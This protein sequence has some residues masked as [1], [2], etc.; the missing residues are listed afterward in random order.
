VLAGRAERRSALP[1]RALS[2]GPY[3]PPPPPSALGARRG[4]GQPLPPAS[5]PAA[6]ALKDAGPLLRPAPGSAPA[7]PRAR[8][9]ARAAN[10]RAGACVRADG[11]AQ[12]AAGARGHRRA[13]RGADARKGR[14]AGGCAQRRGAGTWRGRRPARRTAACASEPPRGQGAGVR[15]QAGGEPALGVQRERLAAAGRGGMAPRGDRRNGCNRGAA[16]AT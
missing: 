3:R 16:V 10:V 1:L 5:I 4:S 2:E 15:A 7:R 8:A 13:R 11:R 6:A 9:P 14:V 12:G